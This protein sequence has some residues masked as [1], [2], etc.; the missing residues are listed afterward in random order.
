MTYIFP[1]GKGTVNCIE[2]AKKLGIP[3]LRVDE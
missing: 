3:V 1:G 2:E